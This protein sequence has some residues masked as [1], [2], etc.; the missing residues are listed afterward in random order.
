[1]A[2]DLAK[3]AAGEAAALWVHSGM[4]VG[5]GTGSTTAYFIEALAR[6]IQEKGLH[7]QGVPTSEAT[8]A[9]ATRLGIPLVPLTPRTRP[10]L[11]VDGADEA[12]PALDLIKGGGGALVREKLVAAAS[13]HVLIIA[14]ASKRVKTLGAFPLPLAVVPY[15]AENLIGV[16]QEEFEVQASVRRRADG[17]PFLSDDG[18]AILDLAFGVVQRPAILDKRLKILPGVVETG[19]FVNLAT[20]LLCGYPDGKVEAFEPQ[21]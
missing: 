9:H 15:A 8:A 2:E 20:Q 21:T 1:M 14:D 16:L 17:V 19:I 13:T 6:R 11:T 12:N 10:D 5:I 18:L 3:R 7:I 4:T